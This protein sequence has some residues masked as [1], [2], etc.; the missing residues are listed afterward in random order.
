VDGQEGVLVSYLTLRRIVGIL[1]IGLPIVVAI[2]GFALG[3]ALQPSISDYY[4]LRTRDAFVGILFTDRK[5]TRLN[6]SHV[7]ISYAVFC[8]IRPHPR[9]ALFPYTTLFRS[10]GWSGGRARLLPDPPPNRRHPRHRAPHRRRDMGL[11]PWLRPPT[12][13]Q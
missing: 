4:A 1:G 9:C 13:D 7:A 11:R 2:W 5:S 8:L 10:C 3:Y 6:S 12:I